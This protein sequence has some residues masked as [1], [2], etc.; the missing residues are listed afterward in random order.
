MVF[1]VYSAMGVRSCN[2]R[3]FLS[4]ERGGGVVQIIRFEVLQSSKS[5]KPTKMM[6]GVCGY[7]QAKQNSGMMSRPLAKTGLL[8]PSAR[9]SL[10]AD[11]NIR[12][13]GDGGDGGSGCVYFDFRFSH[14]QPLILD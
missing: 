5:I 3:D 4:S 8:N 9:H 7:T 6:R 11:C 13:G 12:S 10:R 2:T 1:L 14:S